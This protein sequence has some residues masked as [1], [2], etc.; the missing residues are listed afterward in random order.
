[1]DQNEKEPATDFSSLEKVTHQYLALK[2]LVA[3]CSCEHINGTP[4]TP[5]ANKA[6]EESFAHAVTRY[7]QDLP[8]KTPAVTP[9][10]SFK[11]TAVSP[12]EF[13]VE[14]IATLEKHRLSIWLAKF[15][16]VL[17]ALIVVV[18]L[19]STVYFVISSKSMPDAT[20]LGAIIANLND[21]VL[22]VLNAGKTP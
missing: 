10:Y 11:K 15:A 3:T 6:Q 12:E 21:I 16:V 9:P 8:E 4:G 20:L 14:D 2:A 19:L 13:S 17:M 5:N 1:M 7:A 18:L 22:A